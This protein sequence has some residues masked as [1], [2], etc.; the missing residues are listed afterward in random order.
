VCSHPF[1]YL[2]YFLFLFFK[3]FVCARRGGEW[4]GTYVSYDMASGTG[5]T[6]LSMLSGAEE[7]YH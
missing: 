3:A 4:H 1:F 7:A 5:V 2:F 6:F